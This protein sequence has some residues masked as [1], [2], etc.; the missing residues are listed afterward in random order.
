MGGL[1]EGTLSAILLGL[2]FASTS[3][4]IDRR[5]ASRFPLMC[6]SLPVEIVFVRRDFEICGNIMING[7]L[8]LN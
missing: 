6:L 4:R 7:I 5:T 2:Y 1:I 8:T 3:D